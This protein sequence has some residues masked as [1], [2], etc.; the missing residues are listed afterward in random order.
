M[1]PALLTE[2][3][4]HAMLKNLPDWSLSDDGKAI[5]KTFRFDGFAQAFA[6][7]TR[8]AQKAEE[9]DHHPDWRNVYNRL[10]VKLT[11]HDQGGLTE[12]D[13]QLARIMDEEAG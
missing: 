10:E 7:M 3:A 12:L 5:T 4:C 9:L 6:F 8:I 13:E 1:R 2:S 11:T